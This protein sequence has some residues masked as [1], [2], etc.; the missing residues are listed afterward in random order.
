MATVVE[1]LFTAARVPLPRAAV[2]TMSVHMRLHLM[3]SGNF[4]TT[5]PQSMLHH[6]PLRSSFKVL[7]VAQ[8]QSP[9]QIGVVRLESSR[10]LSPVAERFLEVLAETT[11]RRS[12]WR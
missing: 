8:P 7:P 4:V 12:G 2:V 6:S 11:S 3:N 10:A 5:L 9:G 1:R